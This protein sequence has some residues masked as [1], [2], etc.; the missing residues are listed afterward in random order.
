MLRKKKK[1]FSLVELLVVVVIIGILAG[2]AVIAFGSAKRKAADRKAIADINAV[3]SALDQYSL[4]HGRIYP[5][6]VASPAAN[7]MTEITQGSPIQ[8]ALRDY[9]SPT[10]AS[11]GSYRYFYI[12][13]QTGTKAAVV[14]DKAQTSGMCNI[15][16]TVPALVS[17]FKG[18]NNACYYVAR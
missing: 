18:S 13:N 2:L 7:N 4:S 16:G 14:L 5:V 6:V 15:S 1:G 10:P 8:N 17:W 12:Y 9:I 11:N 3:A